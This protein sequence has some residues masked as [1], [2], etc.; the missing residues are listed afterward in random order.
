MAYNEFADTFN[1]LFDI[2]FP[3]TKANNCRRSCP[4][5][6]WFSNGLLVSRATKLKL[7]ALSKKNPT[8]LNIV[9]YKNY[10]NIFNRLVR[11]AKVKFYDSM[12]EKSKFNLKQTWSLFNKA[13]NKKPKKMNKTFLQSNLMTFS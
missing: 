9:N 1:G 8:E 11:A 3:L 5:E 7:F 12:F 13:I 10:R 2:Y 4:L 6:E